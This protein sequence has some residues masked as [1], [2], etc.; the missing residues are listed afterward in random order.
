MVERKNRDMKT[1]LSILLDH[2]H[3]NWPNKL[4]AIRFA[5]NS[6][7]CQTTGYT[8]AYLMFTRELRTPED[9]KHDLQITPR[10]VSLAN[11]LREVK[12]TQETQQDTR[13]KYADQKRRPAP[14]FKPGDEVL[15]NTH[16][17]SKASLGHT[18][19]FAPKRD[20]PYVILNAKEPCSYEI[21][22]KSNP[23]VPLGT[24][25]TSALK[26]FITTNDQEVTPIQPI[27]R[28]GRPRKKN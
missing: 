4:P 16:S 23:T 17:L 13:K 24:Y 3:T 11:T 28:R 20:G 15:V 14:I 26:H 6:T 5:M 9:I 18:S 1:Q 10:L 22:A 25:H 8:A 21:A 27:R 12:D 2:E 7:R 19:K